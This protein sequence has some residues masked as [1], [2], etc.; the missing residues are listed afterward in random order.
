[1][2]QKDLQRT[3]L[4]QLIHTLLEAD[5]RP[6]VSVSP[7]TSVGEAVRK[8]NEHRIGSLVVHDNGLVVGIITERDILRRV[9][10]EQL[11]PAQT[12]V[13]DVMTPDV[14]YITPRATV[15]Q[16][17]V[18]MTGQRLRHLPA[19]DGGRL[20]GMITIGDLAAWLVR[21]Q[22]HRIDDLVQY[23]S[24]GYQSAVPPEVARD[25]PRQV[26]GERSRP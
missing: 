20:L 7:Q 10:A 24:G 15:E 9:V 21:H 2:E 8:M 13:G 22:Q 1:M 3:D 17:M 14:L 5:K 23:I 16:A 12:S 25:F 26:S 6:V 18:L 11:A 19:I 4:G